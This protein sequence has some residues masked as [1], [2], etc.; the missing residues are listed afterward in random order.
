M[1]VD[2]TMFRGKSDGRFLFARRRDAVGADLVYLEDGT[3]DQ[4]RD[5]TRRDLECPMPQCGDR[6]LTTVNRQHRRDGFRHLHKTSGHAPESVHHQQGKALVAKWVA[7]QVRRGLAPPATV[8]VEQ[9]TSD[10]SRR[11]DVMVTFDSGE[12]LAV[13]IQYSALSVAEYRAR[14]ESY[15]AQG[16][17][18]VWLLGHTGSHMKSVYRE[19]S[20][21]SLTDLQRAIAADG[22]V[23]MWI[24]P[25]DELVGSATV[26]VHVPD[27]ERGTGSFHIDHPSNDS[28]VASFTADLLADC[29]LRTDGIVTPQHQLIDEARPALLVAQKRHAAQL[30]DAESKLQAARGRM[31]AEQAKAVRA[32]AAQPP[33]GAPK[34][35]ACR[36]CGDRLDPMLAADGYHLLC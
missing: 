33:P 7:A 19:T 34:N 10:R 24:N 5:T 3:A 1:A 36:V 9:S 23:P 12:R 2:L 13:E 20:R 6:R 16:I 30:A 27:L 21:L 11:A 35:L 26:E 25:S 29:L 32:C 22:R 15:L 31:L 4:M 8:V 18:P 17:T 28:N 14:N